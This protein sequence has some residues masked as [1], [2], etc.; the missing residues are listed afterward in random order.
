MPP[1][2][3]HNGIGRN[4]CTIRGAGIEHAHE[5]PMLDTTT[6][7]ELSEAIEARL[8][9]PVLL[10]GFAG[11][12]SRELLGLQRRDVD[13]LHGTVTVERQAHELTGLGR[14]LTPPSRKPAAA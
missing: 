2:T 13:P 7:L 3:L 14:V 5:R 12:R 10:G 6:V 1:K 4:P 9:C 8:R 11:M